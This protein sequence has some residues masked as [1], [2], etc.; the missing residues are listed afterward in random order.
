MVHAGQQPLAQLAAVH[1]VREHD[2][3]PGAQVLV[4]DLVDGPGE[5][6]LQQPPPPARALFPVVGRRQVP[7]RFAAIR[8]R[9][10]RGH[11][12]T[13]IIIQRRQ[14]QRRTQQQFDKHFR[15][16]YPALVVVLVALRVIPTTTVQTNATYNVDVFVLYDRL[17]FRSTYTRDSFGKRTPNQ[18]G[19]AKVY[20]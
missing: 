6:Q 12:V 8:R 3:R 18:T 10:R 11:G 20:V 4:D 14:Y 9:I 19:T 15:R 13:I 7:E 16:H 2:H 5:A 17:I 1:L